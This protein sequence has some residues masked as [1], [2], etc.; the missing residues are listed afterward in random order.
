MNRFARMVIASAMLLTACGER[1]QPSILNER[2]AAVGLLGEEIT[3]RFP[4]GDVVLVLNP[5]GRDQPNVRA[6]Q[7]ETV[8]YVRRALSGRSLRTS[9]PVLI[10]GLTA[11]DWSSRIRPGSSAPLSYL[12]ASNAFEVIA[13]DHPH[14]TVLVSLVGMPDPGAFTNVP[15]VVLLLPDLRVFGHPARAIDAFRR[16][17]LHAAAVAVDGSVVLIT[18]SNAGNVIPILD[19]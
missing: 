13:R 9:E 11:S 2:A 3:R 19:W 17:L 7:D 10:D 14:A 5:L 8:E 18:E 16:G 12:M 4:A 1:I 6:L 15:P